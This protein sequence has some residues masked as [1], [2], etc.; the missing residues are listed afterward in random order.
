M[1]SYG[2]HTHSFDG[3]PDYTC[4]MSKYIKHIRH[5]FL[6][7]CLLPYLCKYL[8]YNWHHQKS[9]FSHNSP[10]HSTIQISCRWWFTRSQHLIKPYENRQKKIEIFS[11]R[12]GVRWLGVYWGLLWGGQKD[13]SGKQCVPDSVWRDGG[14]HT[15]CVCVCL[16]CD[17]I[18][19]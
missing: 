13:Y 4:D 3:S 19:V 15:F 9:T 14:R 17:N 2:A 16:D 12:R 1:E 5:Y 6:F 10:K 18:D 7:V 11:F 8:E